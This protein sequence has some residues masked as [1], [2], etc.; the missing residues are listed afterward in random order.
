MACSPLNVLARTNDDGFVG[1]RAS[2]GRTLGVRVARTLLALWWL[3]GSLAACGTAV[4]ELRSLEAGDVLKV[5]GV[6]VSGVLDVTRPLWQEWAWGS[7]LR[8]PP[9]VDPRDV[10]SVDVGVGTTSTWSVTWGGA[11]ELP[12]DPFPRVLRIGHVRWLLTVIV[13]DAAEEYVVEFEPGVVLVLDEDC[14]SSR[15]CVYRFA[16]P[17]AARRAFG[18]SLDAE[19]FDVATWFARVAEAGRLLAVVSIEVRLDAD[20]PFQR[21][22]SIEFGLVSSGTT[23]SMRR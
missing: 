15:A 3:V 21:H 19:Q 10:V 8:F 5:R 12:N 16:D 18:F 20:V 6:P 22:Q 11:G 23:V 4:E 13:S 14:A 17:A 9:S 2:Q 7:A 1:R